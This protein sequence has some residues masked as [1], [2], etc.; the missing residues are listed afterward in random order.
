MRLLPLLLL[1]IGCQATHIPKGVII[2]AQLQPY[3]DDFIAEGKSQGKSITIDNLIAKFAHLD[4]DTL[5]ECWRYDNADDGTPKIL[6][7][8]DSWE[9]ETDVERRVLLFH[10][11]GHCVL[12][13]EHIETWDINGLIVSSIMYPY[14]ESESMYSRNWTYYMWELFHGF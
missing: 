8:I 7:D 10:E 5:G 1:L 14:L 13:R 2:E 11:L 12:N 4:E 3:V 6:I 9:D